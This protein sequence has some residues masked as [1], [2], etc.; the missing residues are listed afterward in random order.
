METHPLLG[1]WFR[2]FTKHNKAKSKTHVNLQKMRLKFRRLRFKEGNITFF[3][4]RWLDFCLGI[5]RFWVRVSSLPQ[6][7]AQPLNT[8]KSFKFTN[9]SKKIRVFSNNWSKQKKWYQ[10]PT[11]EYLDLQIKSLFCLIHQFSKG[12]GSQEEYR[13]W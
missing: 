1:L 9:F 8:W 11:Q 10:S 4:K 7:K 5:N 6:E 2:N 13:V 12:M 3:W